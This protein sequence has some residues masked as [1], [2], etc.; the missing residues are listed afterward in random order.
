LVRYYVV[1]KK[2][3]IVQLIPTQ[4]VLVNTKDVTSITEPSKAPILP[5]TS[6]PFQNYSVDQV[7]EF[8]RANFDGVHI[9]SRVIAILDERTLEDQTCLLVTKK[10]LAENE[11]LTVRADFRSAMVTLNVKNLG[12][13]GDEHFEPTG[14]DGVIRIGDV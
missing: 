3:V 1:S 2:R 4:G 8:A 10:E 6:Y 14:S 7:V 5:P 9:V 13:G 12:V 11:L